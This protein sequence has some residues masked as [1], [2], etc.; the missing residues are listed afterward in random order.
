MAPDDAA[1]FRGG[2]WTPALAQVPSPGTR[3][4]ALRVTAA[5]ERTLRS[6]HPWLFDGAITAQ[7]K[8]GA[9]GDK[10]LGIVN[11]NDGAPNVKYLTVDWNTNGGSEI[12][13]LSFLIMGD[14]EA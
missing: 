8:D 3:R 7:S 2:A 1:P 11:F 5:A 9:P 10:E 13:A 6:G 4:L 12:R 14:V